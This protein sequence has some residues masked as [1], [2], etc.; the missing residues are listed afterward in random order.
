V[1]FGGIRYSVRVKLHNDSNKLKVI[2]SVGLSRG[3]KLLSG[4][5]SEECC[6]D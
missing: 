2:N 1:N 6:Y 3:S 4:D 5:L